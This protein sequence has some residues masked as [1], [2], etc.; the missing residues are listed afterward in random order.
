M[1]TY[2]LLPPNPHGKKWT[3]ENTYKP[4]EHT[5]ILY[6]LACAG[7]YFSN[8][9]YRSLRTTLRGLCS[10][11]TIEVPRTKFRYSGFV[12]LLLT[13]EP[14]CW[15]QSFKKK[16]IHEQQNEGQSILPNPTHSCVQHPLIQQSFSN[17]DDGKHVKTSSQ[18]FWNTKIKCKDKNH[19]M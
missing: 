13:S 3:S 7:V 11:Y 19:Q 15:H 8:C 12:T 1:S 17:G 18:G 16:Q 6:S 2:N 9:T 14:Y 5:D 10:P 4:H